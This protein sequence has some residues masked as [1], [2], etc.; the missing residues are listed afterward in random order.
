MSALQLTDLNISGWQS[1]LDR[2]PEIFHGM[3]PGSKVGLLTKDD[4]E[5]PKATM[6]VWEST[7]KGMQARYNPFP[8]FES[9]DI[10]LLFIA[11]DPTVRRLYDHRETTR[12]IARPGIRG[13]SRFFRVG[14]YGFVSM[15][16]NSTED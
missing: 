14:V 6:L 4:F 13:I 8:G 3:E 7:Q 12:A 16:D 9:V 1:L 10:D 2:Y 5:P 11:D 15:K